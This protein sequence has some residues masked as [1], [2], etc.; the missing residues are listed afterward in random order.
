MYDDFAGTN[1]EVVY[2]GTYN[3][4]PLLIPIHSVIHALM[5]DVHIGNLL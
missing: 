1:I 2:A 3:I 4:Q 5:S